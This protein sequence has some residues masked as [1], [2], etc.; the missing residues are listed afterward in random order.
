MRR[1]PRESVPCF[2]GL[3]DYPTLPAT[4]ASTQTLVIQVS[5]TATGGASPTGDV[6]AA[7]G[8]GSFSGQTS[9]TLV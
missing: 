4:L 5:P 7:L 9:G 6:L 2:V 3:F 1:R 8:V